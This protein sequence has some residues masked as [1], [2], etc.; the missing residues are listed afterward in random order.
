MNNSKPEVLTQKPSM[1][2]IPST[3][4]F[5]APGSIKEFAGPYHHTSSIHKQ[6]TRVIKQEGT[7]FN[8]S[9]GYTNKHN[10]KHAPIK[11]TFSATSHCNN[12]CTTHS[13]WPTCFTAFKLPPLLNMP[14]NKKY[15]RAGETSDCCPHATTH[16]LVLP[17]SPIL[18]AAPVSERARLAGMT[19][20]YKRESKHFPSAAWV[21]PQKPLALPHSAST[22][23]SQKQPTLREEWEIPLYIKHQCKKAPRHLATGALERRHRGNDSMHRRQVFI[24]TCVY[25]SAPHHFQRFPQL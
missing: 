16:S 22:R 10:S 20:P 11:S 1:S 17:P 6:H 3:T 24:T 19:L 5:Q 21:Q 15:R 18:S 23:K 14:L 7:I 9:C 8:I 4:Q 25:L 13:R 12:L 2:A